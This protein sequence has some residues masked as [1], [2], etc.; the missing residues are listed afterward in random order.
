MDWTRL[1]VVWK[2]AFIPLV[3]EADH[4]NTEL[5]LHVGSLSALV[6]LGRKDKWG[7]VV[8]EDEKGH[9]ALCLVNF[10]VGIWDL[11]RSSSYFIFKI[12]FF[13]C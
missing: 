11:L 7:Q 9:I 13:C 6:A 3:L 5:V 2:I 10:Q 4:C 8:K 12:R 1:A